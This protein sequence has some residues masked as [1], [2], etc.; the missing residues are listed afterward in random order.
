MRTAAGWLRP[1]LQQ[2]GVY[3]SAQGQYDLRSALARLDEAERRGLLNPYAAQVL[4]QYLFNEGIPFRVEDLPWAESA[5]SRDFTPSYSVTSAEAYDLR[6]RAA[7]ELHATKPAAYQAFGL[8]REGHIQVGGGREFLRYGETGTMSDRMKG[9]L[10]ATP[11]FTARTQ[12]LR[13]I[14]ATQA[15]QE[16][17]AKPQVEARIRKAI[18]A[19]TTASP[20]GEIGFLVP[21]SPDLL[22]RYGFPRRE[23]V[24]LTQRAPGALFVYEPTTLRIPTPLVQVQNCL[25]V[26]F[27]LIGYD[28]VVLANS[29]EGRKGPIQEFFKTRPRGRL[30]LKAVRLTVGDQPQPVLKAS[31]WREWHRSNLW[32]TEEELFLRLYREVQSKRKS[33]EPLTWSFYL[34]QAGEPE[35]SALRLDVPIGEHSE[36]WCKQD[37]IDYRTLQG[38]SLSRLPTVLASITRRRAGIRRSP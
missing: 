34:G 17:A 31:T 25:G 38:V 9:Q 4:R 27:S 7:R 19:Y 36:F 15:R 30:F 3:V 33:K 5:T 21:S 18:R 6:V 37:R 23:A 20:E 2:L 8:K 22:V 16:A 35:S 32:A 28:V 24:V 29:V 13:T 26:R 1:R 14:Q 12:S 10:E 11:P